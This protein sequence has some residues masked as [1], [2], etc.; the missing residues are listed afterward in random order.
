MLNPKQ[1]YNIEYKDIQENSTV[2]I[3]R[4]T[5]ICRE[6]RGVLDP[7]DTM[8]LESRTGDDGALQ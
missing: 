4:A 5:R 1:L 8:D 2:Y 3:K 6:L 7:T